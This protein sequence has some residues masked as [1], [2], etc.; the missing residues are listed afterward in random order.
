MYGLEILDLWA[1]PVTAGGKEVS[2]LSWVAGEW[3]RSWNC[4]TSSP[5]SPQNMITG[6][7]PLDGC[8]LVVAA[9]DGPMPQTREHLLLAR[10]VLKS[11]GR[12]GRGGGR[13]LGHS[14]HRLCVFLT[15]RLVS[16]M[17]WCM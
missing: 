12:G 7:A 8:I 3:R 16:S 10:Q 17:W 14:G 15:C 2:V 4:T 11:L 13:V 1:W 6:T 5:L 9:N